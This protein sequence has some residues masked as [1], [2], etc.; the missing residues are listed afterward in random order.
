M[1]TQEIMLGGT[2]GDRCGEDIWDQLK[3]WHRAL[4]QEPTGRTSLGS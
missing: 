2:E 3:A 4:S 1:G